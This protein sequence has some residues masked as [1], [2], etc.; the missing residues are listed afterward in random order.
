[1]TCQK[2][3]L[4]VSIRPEFEFKFSKYEFPSKNQ[5]TRNK[6]MFM[7]LLLIVKY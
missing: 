4:L 7:K 2:V 3:T 6:P 5:S 1:M